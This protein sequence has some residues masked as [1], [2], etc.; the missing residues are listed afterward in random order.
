V[1]AA[2]DPGLYQLVSRHTI[3]L[4][5]AAR[6]L[7]YRLAAAGQAFRLVRVPVAGA[8]TAPPP[9]PD[10]PGRR[11]LALTCVLAAAAAEVT[12]PVSLADSR[13]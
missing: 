13:C 1:T 10:R 11:V 4:R 8:V 7:G 9:T 3:E 2:S 12:G 6:A 5:A